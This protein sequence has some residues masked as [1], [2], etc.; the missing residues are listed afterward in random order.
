MWYWP[1]RGVVG[2]ERRHNPEPFRAFPFDPARA[3]ENRRCQYST[4]KHA[5]CH[6]HNWEH[7]RHY[8]GGHH[9][10]PI[11]GKRDH[12][13]QQSPHTHYTKGSHDTCDICDSD[14]RT[15]VFYCATENRGK[16]R[17][18]PAS[19]GCTR[20]AC[21]DPAQSSGGPHSPILVPARTA[22]GRRRARG[23]PSV[24]LRDAAAPAPRTTHRCG[25]LRL[26]LLGGLAYGRSRLVRLR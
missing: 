5:H 12:E 3:R 2:S 19:L 23:V 17:S 4:H 13:Q 10:M 22:I 16:K 14:T 6:A 11:G 7:T 24:V 21:I 25:S 18:G 1:S 20:R 9:H 26:W 8:V 15:E